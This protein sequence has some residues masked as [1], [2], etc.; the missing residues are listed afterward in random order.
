MILA[1]LD[2]DDL[3]HASELGIQVPLIVDLQQYL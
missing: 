1:G 2:L 3:A